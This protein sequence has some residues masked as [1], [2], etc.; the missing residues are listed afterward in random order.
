MQEATWIGNRDAVS[1]PKS[2]TS[3]SDLTLISTTEESKT[4]K[5]LSGQSS[6]ES[7]LRRSPGDTSVTFDSPGLSSSLTS[8]LA[9]SSQ[10]ASTHDIGQEEEDEDVGESQKPV[11]RIR[12]LLF[13]LFS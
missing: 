9:E 11:F 1:K 3:D 2:V 13:L 6:T 12:I 8:S 4:A 5:P 10:Y 7:L